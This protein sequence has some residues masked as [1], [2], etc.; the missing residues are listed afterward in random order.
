MFV[1]II[2]STCSQWV[3]TSAL[4]AWWWLVAN[5]GHPSV[6]CGPGLTHRQTRVTSLPPALVRLQLWHPPS[7][8]S[9]PVYVCSYYL[10]KHSI[11]IQSSNTQQWRKK[12]SKMPLPFSFREKNC[13]NLAVL[14]VPDIHNRHFTIP[15]SILRSF[16][17]VYTWMKMSNLTKDYTYNKI[18]P[19]CGQQT[20]AVRLIQKE[21]VL[22]TGLDIKS[23][24]F[25]YDTQ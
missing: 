1:F 6:S 25:S 21:W 8:S 7:S 12:H 15:L 11:L 14:L 24:K 3:V 17:W 4:I 20:L 13:L 9:W 10:L 5:L 16:F 23:L 18:L 22:W 19:G 2:S